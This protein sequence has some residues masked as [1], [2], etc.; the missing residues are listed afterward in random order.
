MGMVTNE[1]VVCRRFKD[2]VE[3]VF[4]FASRRRHTRCALV[5]GVQTCALPISVK[6]PQTRLGRQIQLSLES[7]GQ[8]SGSDILDHLEPG[9]R[10]SRKIGGEAHNETDRKRVV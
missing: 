2:K 4:F 10:P 5:T 9:S 8:P 7:L 6:R 1:E 3:D